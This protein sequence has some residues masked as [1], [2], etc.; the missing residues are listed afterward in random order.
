MLVSEETKKINNKLYP[1]FD[2]ICVASGIRTQATSWKARVHTTL[3][4]T[5]QQTRS[6]VRRLNRSL[7]FIEKTVMNELLIVNDYVWLVS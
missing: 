4:Q 3:H 2:I 6:P 7:E 1:H 5:M